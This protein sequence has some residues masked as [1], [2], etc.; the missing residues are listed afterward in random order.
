MRGEV[1]K[2]TMK[3]GIELVP[4]ELL[5]K[6]S[7]YVKLAEDNGF[8]YCWITDHYNNRNVYMALGAI[9]ATTNNIKLGPG[10]T[11]P[12]VKIPA[13][14][15]SSL[16]TLD[17]VSGGR[18]VLGIGPGDKATFDALGIKWTKPVATVKKAIADIKDLMAGKRL[19]AGAQ[20][21][22]KPS[23]KVPIYMG[24][25]GPKML[26]TAGMIADGVLINA[27]NPKDF[28]AAVPLIKKGADAA[29][30]N[31]SE[32][33]VAAYACMSVDK[34]PEKAKAAAVPVV[35]FIAAGSPPTVLERHGVESSKVDAINAALKEGNFGAA[36]ETVDDTMLKAFALYGTPEEVVEK[37]KA[38]AKMGVTQ[39]VAG[40]P[41]GP[42]KSTSIKLL[43]KKIIP[44]LT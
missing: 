5:A 18:A 26:E 39:I 1:K 23:V 7:Y 44:E 27:S 6:L 10:V 19:A 41:I 42:D 8:E 16:A 38:L 3:F 30:R 4:N 20:L 12:Y 22:V 35:A 9:A 28:E 34:K 24:A 13:A 21:A 40:S 32:I 37:G 17:E 25:Q 31:M 36:F 29:G 15:A 11:N 14:I 33:D 43:G 2:E